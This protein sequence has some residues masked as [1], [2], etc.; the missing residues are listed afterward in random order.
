MFI[1]RKILSSGSN[2]P[3][4]CRM[5]CTAGV[6]YTIGSAL[7][8]TAGALT[9]ATATDKPQYIALESAAA[10]TK[11]DLLCYP[12]KPDMIFE[13]KIGGNP[14]GAKL[15]AKVILALTNGAATR[16]GI[17]T[18]DGVATIVDK[19]GAKRVG[20]SVFVRFE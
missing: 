8:I 4:P 13:T 17:S 16:V 5:P 3:E 2:V 19:S 10:D 20:D 18:T 14:A 12:V 11:S 6:A 7:V 1:L 9:N 15:G